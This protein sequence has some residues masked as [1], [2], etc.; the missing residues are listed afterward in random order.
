VSDDHEKLEQRITGLLQV[1]T[2]TEVQKRTL[3]EAI[4]ASDEIGSAVLARLTE[5]GDLTKLGLEIQT[6]AI[7][8]I[9]PS[10]EMARALEAETREQLLKTADDAI[11]ERRNAAVEQERR[12]KENEL[13]TE[14][15]VEEKQRQIR[16]T[17]S[18]ANLA[19]EQKEQ[20]IREAKLQGS[21]SLELERKR[22]VAIRAENAKIEADA[23]AY[24][25]EAS[26]K[27]L[28]DLE[29]AVL[30]TLAVQSGDPRLMVSM[31]MKELSRNANKIG[32]LNISPDLLESLLDEKKKR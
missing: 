23:Q 16:E 20:K 28:A 9:K 32:Q 1:H 2:R 7:A 26:L 13:Q 24:A 11:Y 29:P 10:P 14:I 6:L 27:P 15:K 19:V 17:K 22:L 30:Q 12:I 5:S 3:R 21:I 4:Q 31:A 18:D 25:L 8:A